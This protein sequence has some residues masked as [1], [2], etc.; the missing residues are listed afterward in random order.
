MKPNSTSLLINW[1]D[2]NARVVDHSAIEKVAQGAPI[3]GGSALHPSLCEPMDRNLLG[4]RTSLSNRTE[5]GRYWEAR[6]K[7]MEN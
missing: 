6:E 4:Q 1:V 2:R 7:M 3:G 5:C